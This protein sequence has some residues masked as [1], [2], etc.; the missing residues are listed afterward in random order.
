MKTSDSDYIKFLE[1][2]EVEEEKHVLD[3]E[4]YLDDLDK[5]EKQFSDT[6]ETPLTT[7]LKQKREERKVALIVSL[8]YLKLTEAFVVNIPL[9]WMYLQPSL[10]LVK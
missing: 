5:R 3:V 10:L 9:C 6:I 7:F 8:C 4:K 1:S 2:L